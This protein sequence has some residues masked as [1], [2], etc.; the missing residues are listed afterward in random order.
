MSG[1]AKARVLRYGVLWWVN[2]SDL[3]VSPDK[4]ISALLKAG[5]VIS[6]PEGDGRVY[7]RARE[8]EAES[9]AQA[10]AESLGGARMA[11]AGAPRLLMSDQPDYSLDA[12]IAML[13]VEGRLSR[14]PLQFIEYIPAGMTVLPFGTSFVVH[15]DADGFGLLRDYMEDE[16]NSVL[17]VGANG[18]VRVGDEAG[19]AIRYCGGSALS[20]RFPTPVVTSNASGAVTID[21]E[22]Q[23][24]RIVRGDSLLV[25]QRPLYGL[26][27]EVAVLRFGAK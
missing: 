2:P 25:V 15:V 24:L 10:A 5:A 14:S 26:G 18:P 4:A 3:G 16:G 17:L 9:I 11:G 27:L 19:R 20:N 7:F 13:R 21:V 22:G 23:K 6:R 1:A 12:D 8:S